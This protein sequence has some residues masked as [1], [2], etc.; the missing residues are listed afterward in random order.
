MGGGILVERV[1]TFEIHNFVSQNN[2]AKMKG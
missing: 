2:T 1:E